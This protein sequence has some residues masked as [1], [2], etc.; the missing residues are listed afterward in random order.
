[1]ANIVIDLPDLL[2][3]MSFRPLLERTVLRKI[4]NESVP[5]PE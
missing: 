4:I 3:A 1:V 2:N 5:A